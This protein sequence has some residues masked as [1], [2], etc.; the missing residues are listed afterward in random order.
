MLSTLQIPRFI[1]GMETFLILPYTLSSVEIIKFSGCGQEENIKTFLAFQFGN[2]LFL[3]NAF[4][5]ADGRM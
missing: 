2:H 3:L 5:L 1:D 4:P